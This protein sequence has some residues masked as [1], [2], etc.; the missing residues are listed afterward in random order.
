MRTWEYGV[1]NHQTGC[2]PLEVG[3]PLKGAHGCGSKED[4][5]WMVPGP[6]YM[7]PAAM[8]EAPIQAHLTLDSTARGS[9]RR[10]RKVLDDVVRGR[11]SAG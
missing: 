5:W 1:L 2:L 6:Q 10:K 8:V 3:W 4:G 11:T 7:Q 9:R